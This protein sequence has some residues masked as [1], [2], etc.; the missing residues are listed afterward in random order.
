M[1]D[2]PVRLARR[3]LVAGITS[4]LSNW[5]FKEEISNIGNLSWMKRIANYFVL[6]IVIGYGRESVGNDTETL[7]SK[8]ER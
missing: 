3:S 2:V 7:F 6:L 1:W 4:L 8:K 5:V